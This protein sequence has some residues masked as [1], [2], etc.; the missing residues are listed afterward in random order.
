MSRATETDFAI[1]RGASRLRWAVL[2]AIAFMVGLYLTARFGLPFAGIHIV[3][4]QSAGSSAVIGDVGIV[5]LVIALFRL[6]QMLGAI[7]DGELFS[8]TVVR[9][10]RAFAFWLMLMALTGLLGPIVAEIIRRQGAP[11]GQMQIILDFRQILTVGVTLL[12]FLLARLLERARDYEAEA[13]EFV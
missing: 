7:A 8:T 1:R 13:R 4:R 9:R 11:V 2:V 10:F 12:L 6:V 5:L 3:H